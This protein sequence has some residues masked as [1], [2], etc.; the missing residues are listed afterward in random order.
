MNEPQAIQAHYPDDYA[1]CYGCGRLNEH[2]LQIRSYWDGEIAICRFTPAP[3]HTAIPGFVY[4]GLLA[5]LVDCHATGTASAAV[6]RRE[7]HPPGSGPVPRFVT[8]TLNVRYEAP[9]PIDAEL[10]LRATVVQMKGRKVVVHVELFAR[11]ERT[12]TGEVVTFRLE[13]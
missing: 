13:R 6:H 9:T 4:G 11:G 3:Y 1:V 12:V 7:G 2:G 8:G 5:S 10:E